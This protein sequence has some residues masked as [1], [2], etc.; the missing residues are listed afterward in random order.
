MFLFGIVEYTG[1]LV[2]LTVYFSLALGELF[3]L[4]SE[5]AG[6]LATSIYSQK[7]P[8]LLL[9]LYIEVLTD[10]IN[11]LKKH[12]LGLFDPSCHYFVT[13]YDT[14]VDMLFCRRRSCSSTT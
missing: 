1:S 9:F 10:R 4:I 7:K 3:V 6:V 8:I 12:W 11:L 5:R 13:G 14:P 2:A